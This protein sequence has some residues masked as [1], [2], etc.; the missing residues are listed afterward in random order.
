M[1][2]ADNPAISSLQL[3]TIVYYNNC[4]NHAALHEPR[5]VVPGN[6][7]V[8]LGGEGRK[9]G[10]LVQTSIK[11]PPPPSF[12]PN[13]DAK[14]GGRI[15]EQ[16]RYSQGISILPPGTWTSSGADL[17]TPITVPSMHVLSCHHPAWQPKYGQ[18]GQ[19]HGRH[20]CYRQVSQ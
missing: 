8:A 11:R 16:V 6:H 5:R 20:C 9:L 10:A 1:Y 13:Y 19:K 17:A 18:M 15:I 3:L 14:R 2:M 12:S 7:F 4:G